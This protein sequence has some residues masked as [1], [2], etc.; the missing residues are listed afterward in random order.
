[1]DNIRASWKISLA[2]A[3]VA[4]VVVGCG[5][6]EEVKPPAPAP[7]PVRQTEPAKPA[8]PVAKPMAAPAPKPAVAPSVQAPA[9]ELP[10]KPAALEAAYAA[11]PDFSKRV[12]VIYKISD[13]GTPEAITSLGRLFQGE[14]DPDLKTEILDSL[15]DV[16]GLDDRKVA[17]LTTAAGADQ[18]KDVRQS[19]IDGLGE[20][21]PKYALPILQSLVSDPDEEIQDAAKDQIEQ[22]QSEPALQKP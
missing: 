16:D 8:S 13:L 11:N 5:K 12:E 10:Q 4:A 18:P 21:E 6:S 14:K 1:M 22:L 20:L 15:S 7:A 19:A 9:D 3:L 17:I 2:A